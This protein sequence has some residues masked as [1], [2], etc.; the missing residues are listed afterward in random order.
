MRISP[1][2]QEVS[3]IVPRLATRGRSRQGREQADKQ[4]VVIESRGL[5]A[6]HMRPVRQARNYMY[7]LPRIHAN[8]DAFSLLVGLFPL[9]LLRNAMHSFPLQNRLE[10]QIIADTS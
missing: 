10:T 1:V 9:P 3:A 2:L 7:R 5:R 8:I 6:P 4:H